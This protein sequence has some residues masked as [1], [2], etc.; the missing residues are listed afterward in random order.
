MEMTPQPGQERSGRLKG[1][2]FYVVAGPELP[3][4]E[5]R[6]TGAVIGRSAESDI[7]LPAPTVSRRHATVEYSGDQWTISDLGGTNGTFL[8]D[9]RLESSS[10]SLLVEGDRLQIGP[11]TLQIG[12]LQLR[13]SQRDRA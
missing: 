5:V 9:V 10:Q 12:L 11:W 8:N 4:I 7:R 6:E 13:C 2:R 3:V 1:L